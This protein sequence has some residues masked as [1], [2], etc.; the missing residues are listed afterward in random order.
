MPQGIY[1]DNS[2][3]TRSSDLVV[4]AMLP[5]FT[6][7]WG[8]PSAPHA[9]G[10]DAFNGL[11]ACWPA[12]YEVFG[13]NDSDEVLLTG[14]GAEAVNQVILS[15]YELVTT[16]T[17]KN[18]FITANTDEAPAILALGR[19]E[20]FGCVPRS[21]TVGKDGRLSSQS[22]IDVLTP[23]TAMVSV[24]WANAMTG[25]INPIADIG[26]ICQERDIVFHVEASHVIGKSFFDLSEL[27]VHY[28]SF[29]SEYIHGPKGAGA[30]WM[31]KG[32]RS[33]NLVLG[34]STNVAAV[35]GMAQAA[36]ECLQQR[37]Y[38]CTEIAR[39]RDRFEE[40]ILEL[41]PEALVFFREQE[42]VPT[43]SCIAFPGVVNEALLYTLNRKGVYASMGG[44]GFQQ[45]ALILE[46]CGV[47]DELAQ[48]ALSFSLSRDTTEEQVE[49][50]VDIIADAVKK[51]RKSSSKLMTGTQN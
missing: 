30:L 1:L 6:E 49:R 25:V 32:M 9:Y 43:I 51:L 23:R 28:L 33:N 5:F 16:Q 38:V 10:N 24:S 8:I 17:G 34:G 22:I 18:Q 27:G 41:I 12:L 50:A 4:A 3:T 11:A 21:A 48:T 35:V 14:S 46:A 7:R 37:D 20:A 42:R 29:G 47:E 26:K 2:T 44:G 31:R 36:K 45:I 40:G 39:L 13:A 19:L 15:T